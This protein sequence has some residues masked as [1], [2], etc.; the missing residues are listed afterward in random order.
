MI[1]KEEKLEF[2]TVMPDNILQEVIL[3]V[4][5]RIVMCYGKNT[6]CS[7]QDVLMA[8]GDVIQLQCPT[9][10]CYHGVQRDFK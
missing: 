1:F 2:V 3:F 8:I 5:R 6:A 9:L 7:D 4:F 10:Y